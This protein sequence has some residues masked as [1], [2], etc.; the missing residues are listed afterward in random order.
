M[1]LHVIL[2]RKIFSADRLGEKTTSVKGVRID[3]APL[4]ARG[5]PTTASTERTHTR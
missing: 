5:R 2:D 3:F 1:E 4:Q